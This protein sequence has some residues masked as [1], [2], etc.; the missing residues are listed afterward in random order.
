MG[1]R[2]DLIGAELKID[3]KPRKGV[4]IT[5]LYP[6]GQKPPASKQAKKR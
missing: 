6:L 4:T 1:Y 2:A 5:C 3:S